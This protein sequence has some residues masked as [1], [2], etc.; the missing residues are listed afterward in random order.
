MGACLGL[1]LWLNRHRIAETKSTV[2]TPMPVEIVILICH[3]IPLVMVEFMA[4]DVVDM[5]YDHGLILGLIPIV[6]VTSGRLWALLM[7]F[8]VTL[9][10]IAG[11]TIR[12]LVYNEASIYMPLGWLLYLVIPLVLACLMVWWFI[13]QDMQNASQKWIGYALLFNSWLYFLLNYSFFHFPFP[14]ADWTGRTPSGIIFTVC[15]IGLM[16]CYVQNKQTKQE[17]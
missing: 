4:V 1:G 11:K 14:W 8:P 5:F 12:Q 13:K 7:M 15:M 17:S 3:L 2:Y 6:A 16:V 9:I 10:P